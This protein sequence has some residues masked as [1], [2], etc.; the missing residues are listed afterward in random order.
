MRNSIYFLILKNSIHFLKRFKRKMSFKAIFIYFVIILIVTTLLA[1]D[2]YEDTNPCTCPLFFDAFCGTDGNTYHNL[3][4]LKCAQKKNRRLGIARYAAC[5][6]LIIRSCDDKYSPVCGTD[7]N[8]YENQCYLDSEAYQHIKPL[9]IVCF[10]ACEDCK[11]RSKRC[12]C[13][14]EYKPVCGSDGISYLNECFL[15]FAK[16]QHPRLRKVCNRRCAKCSSSSSSSRC[17]YSSTY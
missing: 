6:P 11:D 3:C 16:R 5:E 7:G 15:K 12:K 9:E 1:D 14:R 13:A 17:S 4:S 10:A 8:T 2:R